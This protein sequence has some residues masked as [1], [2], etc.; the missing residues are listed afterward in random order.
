MFVQ[1]A[2]YP[3][4]PQPLGYTIVNHI[5]RCFL[6]GI[7]ARIQ[8]CSHKNVL[9]KENNSGVNQALGSLLGETQSIRNMGGRENKKKHINT[10]PMTQEV[11]ETH[12]AQ[13]MGYRL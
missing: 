5:S 11:M 12:K 10:I 8:D 6:F 7:W 13:K 3:L 1:W 4:R 2:L 9:Y